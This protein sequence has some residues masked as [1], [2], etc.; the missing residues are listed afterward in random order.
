MRLVRWPTEFRNKK[1]K[2]LV[3]MDSRRSEAER[4]I[5]FV[6]F[7][8]IPFSPNDYDLD[9]IITPPSRSHL[10]GTDDTGRDLLSQKLLK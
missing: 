10:L 2:L 9:Y 1:F 7:P 6:I 3:E 5:S 4:K 8:L